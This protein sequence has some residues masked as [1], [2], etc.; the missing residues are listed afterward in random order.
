MIA[1]P[2]QTVQRLLAYLSDSDTHMARELVKEVQTE[3][4]AVEEKPQA[5]TSPVKGVK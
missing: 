3:A 1:L 4:R 5:Q 2:E